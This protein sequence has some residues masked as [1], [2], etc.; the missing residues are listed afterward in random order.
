MDPVPLDITGQPLEQIEGLPVMADCFRSG[1]ESFRPS[2]GF[3][4]V[5]ECLLPVLGPEPVMGEQRR[6]LSG[7]GLIRRGCRYPLL[8]SLCNGGVKLL[9]PAPGAGRAT[10]Y[11]RPR[12]ARRRA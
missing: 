4:R 2:G 1:I 11:R 12:L 3:E 9:A 5:V 7:R 6:T 8:K 10:E